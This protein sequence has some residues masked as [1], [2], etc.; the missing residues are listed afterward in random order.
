MCQLHDT[1]TEF[2]TIFIRWFLILVTMA[3]M[4]TTFSWAACSRVVSIAISV[5]VLPIPALK[6]QTINLSF[7]KKKM[8]PK[9]H[10]HVLSMHLLSPSHSS[11]PA[12]HQCGSPWDL[13]LGLGL[14]STKIVEDWTSILWNA[15]IWPGGKVELCHLQWTPSYIVTLHEE[16]C[17]AGTG[18]NCLK[19]K[20]ML[21]MH[22]P[23]SNSRFPDPH[24]NSRRQTAAWW[25]SLQ[26]LAG[27]WGWLW[28]YHTPWSPCL[29]STAHTF[30]V[31]SPQYWLPWQPHE[32]VL[33][34]PATRSQ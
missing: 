10:M 3:G 23:P 24:A 33:A 9:Q 27:L 25:C 4:S 7:W 28:T 5:P 21:L 34:T 29:A 2:W 16:E 30:A 19:P 6:E 15:M 11:W 31:P 12:V 32:P 13:Y 8:S 1:L 26:T 22:P 17:M 20:A 14:H 18:S